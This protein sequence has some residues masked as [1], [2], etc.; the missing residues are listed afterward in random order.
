[1]LNK[2]ISFA[3]IF[4]L[5]FSFSSCTSDSSK[6]L[7]KFT[8]TYIDF[9]DTVSTVVG[10][11]KSQEAFD[12]NADFI[13]NELSEYHKLYDIYKTYS[14]INNLCTVNKN[15]GIKP[16]EV[17]V[18]IIELLDECIKLYKIT[19]G[20]TNVAMGSVLSLWHKYRTLG[21]DDPENAELPPM[22]KLLEASKHTDITKIIIDREKNTVFLS[23]PDMSLD[24]GAI[25]KGY[26]T[27]RI[28]QTLKAK[29][30]T[31]Y[32]LNIGGNI[33]TL[34]TKPNNEKWTAS[35]VD[36]DPES[37]TGAVM[38]V[39]LD[40]QVFVTSGSYQRY[41]TVDGKQYHH[42]ID[43]KTLM[44]KFDFT[45]VSIVCDDSGLADALSTALFNMSFDEGKKLIE[46][47]EC[48]EAMWITDKYEILY[49]DG[50]KEIVQY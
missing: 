12:A 22:D 45:S 26:A 49:T 20:N 43:P 9:F 27:E 10:F 47:L 36:P 48:V 13:E 42:I 14:G 25:A 7:E 2:I 40:D 21:E 41:Y 18:R 24:V 35:V 33:R 5:L 19:N 1:M 8:E 28:A 37:E 6:E 44:P 4:A 38:I 34:G 15:A 11:D 29:G 32:T 31:G 3:I 16:I 30:I 23:D 17:D 50:F 46:S 39:E